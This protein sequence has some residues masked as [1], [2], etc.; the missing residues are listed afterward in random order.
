MDR[1][2]KWRTPFLHRLLH[3][4]KSRTQVGRTPESGRKQVGSRKE[5]CSKE[6]GIKQEPSLK[7]ARSKLE[8]SRPQEGSK[9][10]A[11]RKQARS[12]QA[13]SMQQVK[14]RF[15]I[16]G[17]EIIEDDN[18][19]SSRYPQVQNPEASFQ[20]KFIASKMRWG[21]TTTIYFI[22]KQ[23]QSPLFCERKCF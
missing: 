4:P 9:Q 10:T 3:F 17:E 1:K 19:R 11:R 18:L 7:H 14:A 8:A 12:K 20:T 21:Y 13:A 5:A 22:P 6:V 16:T 15:K 23:F 2:T